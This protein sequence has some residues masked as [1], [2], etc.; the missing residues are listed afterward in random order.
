MVIGPQ[1][2]TRETGVIPA[3]LAGLM[4]PGSYPHSTFIAVPHDHHDPGFDGKCLA[5][6]L[7]LLA[8]C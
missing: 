2:W 7:K 8:D 5:D 1:H 3:A 4:A 6:G